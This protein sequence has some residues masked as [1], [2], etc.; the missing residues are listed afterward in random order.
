FENACPRIWGD[1]AAAVRHHRPHR[2]AGA[3]SLDFDGVLRRAMLDRVADEVLKYLRHAL[4]VPLAFAAGGRLDANL[5]IGMRDLDLGHDIRRDLAQLTGFGLDGDR[6]VLAPRKIE[7]LA[8]QAVHA[9]CA[10]RNSRRWL[11]GKIGQ[12]APSR[13]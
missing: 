4:T 9:M 7:Q 6:A 3:P 8:D 1:G 11:G 13:E 12:I 10:G 2:V 5:S